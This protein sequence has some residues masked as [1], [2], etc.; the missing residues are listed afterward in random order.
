MPTLLQIN[1]TANWGSTGKIAEQIGLL[2]QQHGWDSYIAYGRNMNP[3]QNKLL[4]IGSMFDVY[5]HYFENRFFDN[6]GRASRRATKK[7]LIEVDKIKPD[8]VHL[9]NIHDHYL[10]YR[11][12]FRYLAENKIPIVWTQHDL[13]S[14]TGHCA[15]NLVGCYKWKVQCKDCP[16]IPFCSLDR[17]LSGYN[18]KKDSFTSIEKMTIVPVSEWLGRQVKQSFMGKYPIQVIKNGID[19]DVFRP[20]TAECLD[21]YGLKE[22]KYVISVATVWSKAKGLEDFSRIRRILHKDIKIVLVGLSE[23]MIKELPDGIVGIPRTQS[24]LELAQLYSGAEALVSLSGSETFGLTIAEALSCGTPAIVYDNTAQPELI[25][26]NTGVVVSNG[27]YHQVALVI[28]DFVIQSFKLQHS[29]DCRF[30]AENMFD[31]TRCFGQYVELYNRILNS[32]SQ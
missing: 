29:Q 19:I 9:H 22:V 2:A 26:T 30:R 15:F 5:E 14:M 32:K 7:F 28:N 6:E 17:S 8:I 12:L 18:S 31:K 4:K 11:L 1:V 21:K 10:N 13:W 25:D 27:D 24:Q 3:S 20:R 23:S 16:V